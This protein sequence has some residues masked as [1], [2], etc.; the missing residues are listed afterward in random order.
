MSHLLVLSVIPQLSI[1]QL[2]F[3]LVE[4]IIWGD[5][6][7]LTLAFN[8][9]S[10]CVC[11]CIPKSFS[12]LGGLQMFKLTMKIKYFSYQKLAFLMNCSGV[13]KADTE[14]LAFSG[15][16]LVFT[17]L[18]LPAPFPLLSPSLAACPRFSLLPLLWPHISFSEKVGGWGKCDSCTKLIHGH[19]PS[20]CR[21]SCASTLG[22]LQH[23]GEQ[24]YP[25][26]HRAMGWGQREGAVSL[27]QSMLS[28]LRTTILSL[29]QKSFSL[30]K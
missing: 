27:W 20:M 15:F 17:L 6:A 29:W 16:C 10:V 4:K 3:S 25:A 24:N 8:V 22:F 23:C 5:I 30:R 2:L 7:V 28:P 26:P 9:I 21:P 13:S 11:D 14:I 18:F 1:W 12:D 19:G